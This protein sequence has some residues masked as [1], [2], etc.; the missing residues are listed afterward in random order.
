MPI[1]RASF[2][3]SQLVVLFVESNN[4]LHR[5]KDEQ[6]KELVKFFGEQN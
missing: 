3:G 6:N 4:W 2:H 1:K 5:G